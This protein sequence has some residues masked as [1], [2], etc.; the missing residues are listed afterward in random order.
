MSER[1]SSR[2]VPLRGRTRPRGIAPLLSPAEV[3]RRLAALERQVEAALGGDRGAIRLPR[4]DAVLHEVLGAYASRR[5]WLAREAGGLGAS[6]VGDASLVAL[7]R[8]WWRVEVIGRERIPAGRVLLVANRGSALLPYEVLMGAT[9]L[10]ADGERRVHP[11]V[12]EWL[13]AM[14]V[15]GALLAALGARGVSAT[16]LRRVLEADHAAIACLEGREAVARPYRE[17]YRVGRL[18]RAALLRIAL[19]TGAPIVPIGVVGVDEVHPVVARF[20]W[21]AIPALLGL[22]ALP[23]TPAVLPLPAKWTLHVGDP[24]DVAARWD[25]AAARDAA[26][27]R[28]LAVQVRERLQGVVSDGLGRR[29]SIFL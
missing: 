10:A 20:P 27:V 18:T 16:R 3:A 22:P 1:D 11:L 28:A 14:P 13:T 6:V 23:V 15:V 4:L 17:A 21:Q 19:E 29:R 5:D 7:R 12:D 2:V 24:L 9:A 25:A 8:W 26:V